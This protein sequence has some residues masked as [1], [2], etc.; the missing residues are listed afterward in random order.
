MQAEKTKA[1]FGDQ[2]AEGEKFLTEMETK[3][4]VTSTGTGLL[5][6]VVM[7]GAGANPVATDQVTVHY[8]GYLE[9]GTVFDSSR[10]RN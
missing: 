9:D 1:Q 5:Y 8:T 3:E 10:D 6:E 4:G 2:E 7:E